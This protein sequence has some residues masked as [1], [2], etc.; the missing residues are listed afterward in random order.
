[1][2]ATPYLIRSIRLINF[3]NFTDETIDLR[4][5][6]HLFL[7]GDN[8]CGKTT[9]L[10]AVHYVLTAGL[11]MEWNSAA[12]M[13]GSKR[14][15]RRVQG[16]IL[17]DNLDTGII[18]KNGAICYVALEIIGRQ[19]KP[20]T[21]G[22][23]MSATALDERI[24]FWGI[25]R[26]CSL[27]DVPFLIEEDG[28]LRPSSRREFKDQLGNSRGFINNKKS[29]RREISE[30][31]F[32][33]EESYLDIC[34]F[35]A[36]GKAYREISAG[37]AD[38]HALFKRLLPEPR[39]AI[40]SQIIEALRTLDESQ[41][42]LDDLDRKLSWLTVLHDIVQDI[43]EQRQAMQRYDWLLCRFSILQIEDEQQLLQQKKLSGKEQLLRDRTTLT[44]L[45]KADRDF[46][47]RLD[48]LKAKDTSGLVLQEKRVQADMADK[49]RVLVQEKKALKAET[50]TL[51]NSK[52]ELASQ[53][54]L[55]HKRLAGFLPG[56]TSRATS[57]PFS[58]STLQTELDQFSRNNDTFMPA[59]FSINDVTEESDRHLQEVNQALVRHRDL[60][61]QLAEQEKLHQ[62]N[63]ADLE[64]QSEVYPDIIHFQDCLRAM[65]QNLLNPRP[66]YL[67]LEWVSTVKKKEQHH[68][69]ECIGEDVL[70]TLFFRDN[71]YAQA[72][73]IAVHYPGVRISREKRMA[74]S[75]PDW[76]RLVFDVQHSDPDCLR[77]LATEMES[78]GLQPQ[79]SLVDGEA[80]LAFRGH[81]RAFYGYP[82]RLIGGESRKKALAVDIRTIKEELKKL[83]S[84]RRALL[85]EIKAEIQNLENLTNFK[86]FLH[87]TISGLQT[88]SANGREALQNRN[89]RQEL[90]VR[91]QSRTDTSRQE[92]ASLST[93]Q[94]ELAARIAGEG[95]ANLDRRIKKLKKEKETNQ[96][97]I[98]E[99]NQKIGGDERDLGQLNVRLERLAVELQQKTQQKAETEE[100][101]RQI[102]PDVEDIAHYV[103]KSRKG[104]QFKSH[105]AIEKEKTNST[106]AA[107]TGANLIREKVNDPEF[108]G[109]FRFSYQEEEN[110][111]RDFREQV[112]PIILEQQ[113]TAL[114]EQK[115][116]INERTR[117]LFKQIIMTDLLDY[118]RGHVGELDRMIRRINAR[119][120]ERSF[121][122]QRYRFRLRPLDQYKRL[123]RIIKKISSF[124]PAAEKELETFFADHRDAIIS[125][126]TGS[127]PEELDYRNWYKYE[128]E[129]STI[130]DQGVVMDRRTKSIGSGGEQAVPNYLLILTIAHFLYQGKKIRL[131]TLLFDEAFYGIDAG[132]RDQLLGFATDLGLQLFIA[133][134]DQDG[135][136]R[137]VKHSTTL[138]VKK[139]TNFDI[140]LY[141]F[142]WQNPANQQVGLF[143]QEKP[144]KPVAF[145]EEL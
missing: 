16:I 33:G 10:D 97:A 135:V 143:D 112:L 25:I 78:D 118:L 90:F 127:I 88:I 95:L 60:E 126:E 116:V 55:Y 93:R 26:E 130:G 82:A 119:L 15:G 138:L 20:L 107:R 83:G 73:K 31:L 18:N 71:E 85:R 114:D 44:G 142:H 4:E 75:L 37:A 106:V 120:G 5:G 125:T 22:I 140:H 92:L 84:E 58:I 69:E 61:K 38:Y 100:R 128:L 27:S 109:A 94:K 21:I 1:M 62:K 115:E 102:L 67:G 141:P 59:E 132:R 96:A 87:D 8:G 145:D 30:R 76:M 65:Q 123:I 124:D 101:L 121:G 47:E 89:H 9:I 66:L 13:S 50:D 48:T 117:K 34:R 129:V 7:L 45:E 80:F 137:E 51:R 2:P 110:E 24:R 86:S 108:G 79:V 43:A 36:M 70:A 6:G 29:Y 122:G 17:R 49:K 68:I 3:H 41:T 32:G 81:E 111:L 39:T 42:I 64:K 46:E 98:R 23:G 57:L 19:G 54:D 77:C 136:R 28:R 104:Q 40:F 105:E 133:S 56:L 53:H 72:R 113:R 35:L 91:Q 52:K 99:L 139:D 103:L 134:P 14:Y 144:V 74:A 12:R 63:L 11:A 131:H